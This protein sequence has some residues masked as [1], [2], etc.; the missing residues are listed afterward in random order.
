MQI[1]EPDSLRFRDFI[2][3]KCLCKHPK[4]KK[5]IVMP[6]VV[7]QIAQAIRADETFLLTAHISPDGDAIGSVSALA[8]LL[9][10]LDKKPIIFL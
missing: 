8:W 6:N 7:S 3:L 2:F 10:K 1:A 5:N 9:I 4:P